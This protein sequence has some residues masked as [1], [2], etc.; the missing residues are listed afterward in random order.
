MSS[1]SINCV[2]SESFSPIIHQR[3]AQK[4]NFNSITHRRR[5]LFLEF[6]AAHLLAREQ[7]PAP[8]TGYF[9]PTVQRQR[10]HAH[11]NIRAY[12]RDPRS[13]QPARPLA[14]LPAPAERRPHPPPP[15]SPP[16]PPRAQ[17]RSPG[18]A[19]AA[20]PASPQSPPR[21]GPAPSAQNAAVRV[22]PADPQ[23]PC[24]LYRPVLWRGDDGLR[25]PGWGRRHRRGRR[26][27]PRGRTCYCLRGARESRR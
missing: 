17:A 20:G 23:R 2:S 19:R 21:R 24:C 6:V 9:V 5:P 1:L 25:V 4:R 13:A 8:C 7:Q 11:A 3:P 26:R 27:P 10:R 14:A 18:P 12:T 15:P 22:I 16:P